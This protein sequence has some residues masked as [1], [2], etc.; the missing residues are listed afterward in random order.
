MANNI[1]GDISPRTA[2]HASKDML[3]RA[4]PYLCLEQFGQAFPL[5]ANSSKQAT[6][7]R[8]EALDKTPA[9]I[10]EGVTPTGRRLTYTDVTCTLKQYGGRIPLTDVILDTHEDPILKQSTDLLGEQ[11][12]QM[13]EVVRFNVI[14]AGTNV[15]FANGSA[16]SAVNTPISLA[17]QRKATRSLKRQNA[18][19]ISKKIAS[20]PDFG[21]Q[22]VAPAYIGLIYPDMGNDVRNMPGFQPAETY[23]SE[24]EGELGK[25]EDV[26]YVESTIFEPWINAGGAAGSMLSTGGTNADVYPVIFLGQDAFGIVPFKGKNAVTPMVVM[27]KPSDSD[28]MGQRGHVSWKAYQAAVILNDLWM[29]RLECAVTA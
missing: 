23:K 4:V 19:K 29:V 11:A 3:V 13:L 21:T 28:P 7:R 6:W 22:N 2:A 24:Y 26:R 14:K 18:R 9:E 20:T 8:Y 5:P 17:M 12:A 1:Y 25:V 15:Q 16:R 10:V 27:P